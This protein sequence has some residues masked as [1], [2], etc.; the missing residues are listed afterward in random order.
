[1]SSLQRRVLIVA[2]LSSFVAFLDGTV[3]NVA[4]PAIVA[5]LGGG[6]TV[7]QWVLDAYLITL[8]SLILLAGSLSDQFGRVRVL[9][10]GL[11][12]FGVASVLCAVAPTGFFLIVARGVQGAAGALLVPSSLAMIIATFS[13]PAQSLAIGRWTAWSGIAAIIGPVLGGVFVDAFSWRWVFGINVAPI[14][15]TVV[16]LGRL[17]R[18]DRA[19]RTAPATRRAPIDWTGAALGV[20]G[21]AGPVFALIEQ[22]RFGWSSPVVYGPLVVGVAA[23]LAFLQVERRSRHPMLPLELFGVRNFWVGNLATVGIYGAL[24]LG[25]FAITLFLQQVAG[26]SAT[27][28]GV[29]LIPVTVVMLLLSSVFG[30]LAGR[31]GPRLFMAAGPIL[32]GVGYLL[33]LRAEI[34]LQLWTQLMPGVALFGVGLAMTVAPLTSAVL[35]DIAEAHAGIG[36]AVNNAVSRVAGLVAIAFAGVIAGGALDL[37]GF[38]R[39]VAWTAGLLILSGVVAALGITN[40]RPATGEGS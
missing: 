4:L 14:A 26:F 9:R 37:D 23:F 12:G 19:D 1:M 6:L 39:L 29:V 18:L 10:I 40:R 24:S 33:M 36:S 2:V 35:G 27:A 22:G 8:G 25:S 3:V 21:L 11:L 13:G 38:H 31:H 17:D 34:P 30:G 32:A 15:V 7:Q 16:L 20:V 5:D 28:S